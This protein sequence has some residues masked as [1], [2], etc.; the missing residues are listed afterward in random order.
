L[1]TADS[2]RRRFERPWP[3]AQEIDLES[4]VFLFHMSGM[5][6]ESSGQREL[7]VL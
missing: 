3:E 5:Q 1:A 4:A 2:L 6:P 7:R